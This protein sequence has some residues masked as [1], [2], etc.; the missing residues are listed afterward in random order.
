MEAEAM[1]EAGEATRTDLVARPS[2]REDR[3]ARERKALGDLTALVSRVNRAKPDPEALDDLRRHFEAVPA[4]SRVLCDL[5]DRN[6]RMVIGSIVADRAAV[7]ALTVSVRSLRDD[8]GY[9]DATALERPL[10]EHVALCWLRLQKAEMVYSQAQ[11]DE[12]TLTLAGWHERRLTAAHARY[13]RASESLA[14]VRRLAQPHRQ[15]LQV[16]IG[17]QQVN[18]VGGATAAAVNP[19]SHLSEGL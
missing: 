8:L 4:L 17:G 5:H 11:S 14:R 18:V 10:I 16:N 6:T 12:M 2:A 9:K 15:P 7:E 3:V 19:A 1:S 13:V